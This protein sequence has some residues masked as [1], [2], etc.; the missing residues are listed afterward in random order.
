MKAATTTE[1]ELR[2]IVQAAQGLKGNK[3]AVQ[4][5]G[6]FALQ[7]ALNTAGLAPAD[8]ERIVTCLDD[9]QSRILLAGVG[10]EYA[11]AS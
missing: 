4:L 8:H 2:A 1:K 3:T 10:V 6:L 7:D 11:T 9:I 5:A